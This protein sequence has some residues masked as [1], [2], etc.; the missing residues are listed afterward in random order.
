[1][2]ACRPCTR[3]SA[4]PAVADPKL[5][6]V[7]RGGEHFRTD[8]GHQVYV[9]DT[10]LHLAAATHK[11]TLISKLLREGA[12]VR[13]RNRRGAEPLH[14][15]VDGGPGSPR[16]DPI[17]QRESIAV[18]LT[19]GADPNALDKNGTSPLHRA[20]RNRCAD[21]VAALLEGGADPRLHNGSG[22]TPMDLT[23]WTTGRG[24]S[25]S[26]TAKAQ[27]DQIVQL[28]IDHGGFHR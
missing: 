22:S 13:A 20:V 26:A 19:A 17:A 2:P 11:P 23:Q 21:A 18:L 3:A 10:P 5:L 28:L 6:A 9:G 25:G 4:A 27:R 8:I 24:G 1:L 7:V 12:D 16:W 15:A 14:Y